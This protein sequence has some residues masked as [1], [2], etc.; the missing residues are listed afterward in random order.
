MRRLSGELK[1]GGR[2]EGTEG[3]RVGKM[4]SSVL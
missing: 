3:E 4:E 2:R 1:A